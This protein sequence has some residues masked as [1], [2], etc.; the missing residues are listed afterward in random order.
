M[1]QDFIFYFSLTIIFFFLFKSRVDILFFVF[2][3]LFLFLFIIIP[4]VVIYFDRKDILYARESIRTALIFLSGLIST[5]FLFIPRDKKLVNIFLKNL[6]SIKVYSGLSLYLVVIGIILKIVGGD[7]VHSSIIKIPWSFSFLFGISDRIYYFGVMLTVVNIYFFGYSKRNKIISLI[8]LC[9]GVFGG[10]RVTI[11]LPLSFLIILHASLKGISNMLKMAV[12]GSCVL[13]F[14]VTFIGLFRIDAA[15][16]L[17]TS[18][19]MIDLFLFRISEFYWPTS[20]IEII[21]S[22][23][24]GY[25]FSWIL[26]GLLGAFPSSISE[27]FLGYSIFSR[28]TDTMLQAGLGSIYMSVPMTPI[29]EGYYW[30]GNYGILLI[31][32]IY[33]LGFALILRTMISLN[34]VTSILVLV[35]MYRL[36]F[37]LP[38]AAYAEFISFV[39]KDIIISILLSK[40]LMSVH[41]FLVSPTTKY[42]NA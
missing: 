38:V 7:I 41:S 23:S 28:D 21:D 25:Q 30:F 4:L 6:N 10:S 24:F 40:I 3:S 18:E 12:M 32:V 13:I 5:Y 29:G 35:Q 8:I 34:P 9:L 14:T 20:F 19:D 17:F 27:L 1:I 33:G 2:T 16:R 36:A 26:S 22:R 42:L 31:G 11:L 15:D 37:T 39:S